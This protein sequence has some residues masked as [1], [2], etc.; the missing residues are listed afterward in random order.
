MWLK[1]LLPQEFPNARILTY[2]FD[3]ATRDPDR[4]SSKNIFH[5]AETF[6]E[7]LLQQRTENP[8]V[9]TVESAAISSNVFRRDPLF[10]SHT[11]LVEL[12]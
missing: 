1:D 5:H 7:R 11:V 4:V 2:G 9:D 8:E 12:C 6:I 10:L 3:A